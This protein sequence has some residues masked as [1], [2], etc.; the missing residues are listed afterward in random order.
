MTGDSS[1]GGI[2]RQQ[3]TGTKPLRYIQF[4]IYN[5]LLLRPTRV[6]KDLSLTLLYSCMSQSREREAV[7]VSEGDQNR[8]E[9]RRVRQ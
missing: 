8:G 3:T 9:E 1:Q 5:S 6:V 4:S 7:T 2:R